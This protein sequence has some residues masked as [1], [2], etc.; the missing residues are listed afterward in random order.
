MYNSHD[1]RKTYDDDVTE[2]LWGKSEADIKCWMANLDRQIQKLVMTPDPSKGDPSYLVKKLSAR[3]DQIKKHLKERNKMQ[4]GNSSIIAAWTKQHNSVPLKN[5][6]GSTG[7]ERISPPHMRERTVQDQI[8]DYAAPPI[9]V[10][11]LPVTNNTNLS[12]VKEEEN[13]DTEVDTLLL[14]N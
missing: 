11:T 5:S 4:T 7:S 3:V 2:Q 6:V 1:T 14:N 9:P 10:V 12:V 13:E 8:W